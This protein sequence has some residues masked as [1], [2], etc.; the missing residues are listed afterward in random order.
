MKICG[1]KL[2]HDGAV[3][4]IENGQ[5]A[6]SIEI[7]KLNNNPRYSMISDTSIIED[8]LNDHGYDIKD[9]DH[10]AIDGWGGYNN[11]ELAIQPRLRIT[12]ESNF[13]TADNAGQE[14]ELRIAQYQEKTLQDKLIKGLN[15]DGLRINNHSF[16]YT[17]YFHVAGH[18]LSAYCT[19]PFSNQK[20]SAFILIW[21]GG[22]F[23]NLY[24]IN[25]INWDIKCYGPIFLLIG[26]FYTI[27]SQFFGPFK[28]KGNFAKDNLSVA[29]KVMAYIAKGRVQPDLIEIFKTLL[30][31][32]F[33]NI[34]GYANVFAN[35]FK[36]ILDERKIS[37][38][39]EDIL[40]SFHFFLEELLIEKLRKK[41]IRLGLN[42]NNL[43]IAG[44]CGLNIKWNSAIRNSDLFKK[45]YVPPFPNDSG[46][47]IGVA[48]AKMYELQ[49]P[50][51]LSWNVYSGPQIKNN[52]PAEGW[53]K[54]DISL[55]DLASLLFHTGE[56]LVF[57]N[58]R[59]E[60]GPRALGNRSILAAADSPNIKGI[61]NDLKEREHYRPVSPICLEEYAKDIFFPGLPDPYM[62]YDHT[63]K[64]DWLPR[65]PGVI[66][67]DNT[68]RLQTVGR[69]D[70]PTIHTLLTEYWKISGIPLLCNTS[71][72]YNGKG[73]FPDVYSATKW[74]KTKYVWCNGVLYFKD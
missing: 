39:D 48:C 44:G 12:S 64:D 36:K 72:N 30:S 10:F 18:V 32:G 8:I 45:V 22:M 53:K 28:I 3:S 4:I 41:I 35:Q 21:D 20:E 65:I 70:N 5:L 16:S 51:P 63:V 60:L 43:C 42:C 17:T 68:A 33:D 40:T 25:G 23:P 19:S 2:T 31:Q 57:L 71:A 54:K 27:F 56:P 49:G 13:L 59:A 7:E 52:L 26:N 24:H 14:Y 66:H 62:L 58:E 61:L 67:L 11:E 47:A 46:S 1:L 73:F 38:S 74:G 37:Y 55:T 34:M 29:G 50:T 6:F 9:V 69:S 15:F